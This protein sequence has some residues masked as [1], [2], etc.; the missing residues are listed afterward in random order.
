MAEPEVGKVL[1]HFYGP[2][3]TSPNSSG[4]YSA[5]Q[6][7]ANSDSTQPSPRSSTLATP[8]GV[9]ASEPSPNQPS[10]SPAQPGVAVKRSRQRPTKSCERCRAKKLKCDRELPCSN[11]KKGGRDGSDCEYRFGPND[12]DGQPKAKRARNGAEK[13]GQPSSHGPYHQQQNGQ[14]ADDAV[15]GTNQNFPRPDWSSNGTSNAGAS[16]WA[17]GH[18]LPTSTQAVSHTSVPLGKID[19]KGTRS[20]YIGIGDKQAMLDHVRVSSF[21]THLLTFL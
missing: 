16:A 14:V 9:S 2:S 13:M 19:V 7:R 5:I 17:D 11:C 6:F 10:A 21:S 18:P 8:G 20:R 3:N 12:G 1:H 15:S 4:N